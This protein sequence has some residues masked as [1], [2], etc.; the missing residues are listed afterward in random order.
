VRKV[1][2]L[3]IIILV[4]GTQNSW[5]QDTRFSQFNS[6]PLLINP[7][8]AGMG[9]GYSRANLNY[10]SQ[11]SS[12]QNS[13]TTA[14]VSLDFP[15]FSEKM[16]WKKGYLGT[17][18]AFYTD[19]AGDDDGPPKYGFLKPNGVSEVFVRMIRTI[20]IVGY[21]FLI[22][23]YPMYFYSRNNE[24]ELR[25]EFRVITLIGQVITIQIVDNLKCL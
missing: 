2:V 20:H 6:T 18:L 11:W 13:F 24:T 10:R 16:N 7:G 5:A 1:V 25:R 19:K 3:L 15:I 14:A 17:G 8:L 4:F 23:G 22:L 12:I 21:V 9:N